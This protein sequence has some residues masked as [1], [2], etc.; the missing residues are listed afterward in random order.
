MMFG[1]ADD[2]TVLVYAMVLLWI[3]FGPCVMAALGVC[4]ER[5]RGRLRTAARVC[6]IAVPLVT[7]G[8]PAAIFF[9]VFSPDSAPPNEDDTRA[10]IVVYAL[11]LTATPW[12]LA[13]VIT[14]AVQ[15]IRVRSRS[16]SRSR[17]KAS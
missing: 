1:Y 5:P 13:R 2:W 8:I 15:R 11:L 14:R 17:G 16:R 9:N 7:V 3:P 6:S 12:V 4:C 10:F